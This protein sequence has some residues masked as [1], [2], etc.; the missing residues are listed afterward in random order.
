MK[1]EELKVGMTVIYLPKQEIGKITSWNDTFVFV[2]YD[3][4]GKGIATKIED[5]SKINE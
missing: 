5:L 1:Q 3:G 4:T 2:D